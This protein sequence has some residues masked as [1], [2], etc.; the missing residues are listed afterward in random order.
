MP[1]FTLKAGLQ[2][3]FVMLNARKKQVYGHLP[4]INANQ[5]RAKRIGDSF[6]TKHIFWLDT[7]AIVFQKC[8][9]GQY[10]TCFI[11]VSKEGLFNRF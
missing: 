7:G 3:Q 6:F 9:F 2:I 5:G 10:I 1:P 8:L 4:G 11:F